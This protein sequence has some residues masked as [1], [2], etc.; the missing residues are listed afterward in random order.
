MYTLH[1]LT[2]EQEN[3]GLFILAIKDKDRKTL[4]QQIREKTGKE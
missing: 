3:I 1:W 4:E 2:R